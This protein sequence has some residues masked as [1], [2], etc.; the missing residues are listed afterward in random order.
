MA[1]QSHVFLPEFSETAHTARS[2]KNRPT[3]TFIAAMGAINRRNERDTHTTDHDQD[4]DDTHAQTRGS[5]LSQRIYMQNPP[6]KQNKTLAVEISGT[7]GNT[8][9]KGPRNG[10]NAPTERDSLKMAEQ[11][12]V[13]LPEFSETARTA[14][15]DKNGPTETFIAAMGAINRGNKRDI[16]TRAYTNSPQEHGASKTAQLSTQKRAKHDTKQNYNNTS[17]QAPFSA[18]NYTLNGRTDS[19]RTKCV[20]SLSTPPQTPQGIPSSDLKN[21]QQ[22][23]DSGHSP[24]TDHD[25]ADHGA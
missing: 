25:D 8:T 12:H 3:E 18:T 9:G 22:S 15:S 14:R 2:D 7:P 21:G 5:V 17:V 23:Y 11:S 10:Q 13:F 20:Q 4:Y 6:I 19:F 24:R 1:E 16:H